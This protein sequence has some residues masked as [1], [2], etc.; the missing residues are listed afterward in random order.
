[1]VFCRVA[2]CFVV[3]HPDVLHSVE[4]ECV[5]DSSAPKFLYMHDC[6]HGAVHG[7]GFV[8]ALCTEPTVGRQ[9]SLR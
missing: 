7:C 4:Y 1:M 3:F 9:L 8:M 2:F 5:L 6:F